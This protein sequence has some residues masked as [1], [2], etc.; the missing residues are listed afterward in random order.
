MKRLILLFVLAGCATAPPPP[1]L[2]YCPPPVALRPN[3][4]DPPPSA[5]AS[6]LVL[7][8]AEEAAGDAVVEGDALEAATERADEERKMKEWD[9]EVQMNELQARLDGA[10]KP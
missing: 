5:S 9:A 1:C 7:I 3:P 8:E 4:F 10:M 2:C 6:A